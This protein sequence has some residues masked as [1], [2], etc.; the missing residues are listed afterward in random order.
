M[1]S[2]ENIEEAVESIKS[3]AKTRFKDL[4][5]RNDIAKIRE[6]LDKQAPGTKKE[7]TYTAGEINAYLG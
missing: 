2:F 6:M 4:H 3:M 1:D 5:D 7:F